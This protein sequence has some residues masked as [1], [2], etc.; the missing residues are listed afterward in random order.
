MDDI[1]G[2]RGQR[3]VCDMF[4]PVSVHFPYA[5]GCHDRALSPGAAHG[6]IRLARESMAQ[7][8]GTANGITNINNTYVIPHMTFQ[9]K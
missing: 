4:F 5:V 8:T 9:F 3:Y 7:H 6:R 2:K 1:I